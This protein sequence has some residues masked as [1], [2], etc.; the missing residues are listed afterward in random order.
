[1]PPGDTVTEAEWPTGANPRALLRAAGGTARKRELLSCA[2]CRVVWEHLADSRSRAAVELLERFADGLA[3]ASEL[4]DARR[5][6][7]AVYQALARLADHP[8]SGRPRYTD[9][10]AEA[11]CHAALAVSYAVQGALGSNPPQG[12]GVVTAAVGNV[13]MYL[14]AHRLETDGAPAHDPT[15]PEP[16]AA[17]ERA[18]AASAALVRDIFGN[19]FRP[20]AFDSA[21]RTDTAV[22]LAR[23]MYDSRDFGALPILAD[24]LQDAGCDNDDVLTHCRAAG[25]THV[26]GCWVV[27]GVLGLV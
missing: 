21:W 6:C 3:T 15:G 9:Y 18:D 12:P 16:R 10:P 27:D 17:K 25:A 22:T 20:V 8:V 26:R 5:D 7:N 2:C 4:T 19:P 14:E 23:Q 1:M 13:A 24:A 11:A